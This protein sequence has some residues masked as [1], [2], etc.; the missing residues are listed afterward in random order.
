M[1]GLL[2]E[3]NICRYW[4]LHFG[5]L[6]CNFIDTRQWTKVL[7]CNIQDHSMMLS[8]CYG[9]LPYP[10]Q[11]WVRL[12]VIIN[13]SAK[14]EKSRLSCL[15]TKHCTTLTIIK[16]YKLKSNFNKHHEFHEIYKK[17]SNNN[18]N[19]NNNNNDNNNDNNNNNNNYNK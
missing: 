12:S 19:N 2:Y 11:I 4:P 10:P 13:H 17:I 6:S 9:P 14:N 3:Q 7:P 16:F 8:A 5:P 1:H 18:N 15:A